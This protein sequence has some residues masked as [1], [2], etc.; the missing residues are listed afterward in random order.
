[1]L[2]SLLAGSVIGIEGYLVNIEVDLKNGL[3]ATNIVGLPDKAVEESKERVRS[4][5]INSGFEYPTK[6]ITINL[7]PAD[8]KKEGPSF[9]LSIA[10]GMLAA[11]S[12]LKC[13]SLNDYIILGELAL[14]SKV[15]AVKG[16]LPV[17]V[18]AKKLNKKLIVPTDNAAEAA[19]VKGVE[20]YGVDSLLDAVKLLKGEE[21]IF[22]SEADIDALFT[23]AMQK[24]SD[25]SDVKGQLSCRRAV[26]IA[27]A[28]GHN[29][30]MIGPPGSGKSMISKRIPSILPKMSFAEAVETTKIHSIAGILKTPLV[31]VRPF[32]SPHHTISNIALVG[33]GTNPRPGEISLA[34]HG[35][36]FL[37]EIPE[38]RR[39][40]LEVLRQPLEDGTVTISRAS[41]SVTFPAEFMTVASMNPCPCG[42]FGSEIKQCRCTD[43]RIRQYLNKIS[44]PLLD[45]IDI[46]VE[47]P[48]V[49]YEE[50]RDLKEGESSSDMH[51]RIMAARKIQLK[52]FA[53]DNIFTN[54][55]MTSKHVRKYCVLND[56]SE[57]LLKTAVNSLG[58][59]ARAYTKILK[60]ARTIADMNSSENIE[61][62]HIAEAISFRTLDRNYWQ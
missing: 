50:L 57:K 24:A 25:F 22:P 60:I 27:V 32:R 42:Y 26:E 19:V 38:F 9:D 61:S 30:L 52:R 40:V 2:S 56:D 36:L 20:V 8:I 54:A 21:N 46:H 23:E 5:L 62:T 58:V 35:V 4:A 43:N 6:R 53:E 15:R 17:A 1:M 44:G 14:G 11:S 33:G 29:I 51:K 59:S 28:G 49:K 10:I 48:H 55:K 47:V 12:Q 16:V 37:D 31:A 45:R 39:D 7:A 34:H 41:G 13:E 3:P 18:L